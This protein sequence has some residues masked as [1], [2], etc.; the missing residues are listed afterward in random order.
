MTEP[1]PLRSFIS[2]PGDVGEERVIAG[3]V[4]DRLSGG[5]GQYIDLDPV[6]WEGVSFESA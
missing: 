6:F 4:I 5:F 3:R 1:R 2:P